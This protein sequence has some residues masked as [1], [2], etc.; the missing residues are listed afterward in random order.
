MIDEGNVQEA[1][2]WWYQNLAKTTV[3]NF[4]RRNINAQYVLTGQEALAKVLELIPN[5]ATVAWGDSIT[6]Q[7]I[8]VISE[9]R[10]TKNNLFL[11]SFERNANGSLTITGE[12]RLALMRKAMTADVFLT[13]VNAIT[14]DGKLLSTDATGNRV[15]PVIFGPKRVI[16]VA[17]VNKIVKTLD[18]AFKRIRE[19]AAPIN[20][21]RHFIAHGSQRFGDLPCVKTGACTDCFHPDRI[22]RHTI[23]IE[24]ERE[25]ETVSGYVPRIHVILVGEELGI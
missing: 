3:A 5:G 2:K 20:A 10:R 13:G 14:V 25:P 6:L 23:I 22:C 1:K 12:A 19:V 8:G 9:L 11:D 21:R 17:G 4:Q 15:A 18:E 7:Q 16:I 24:G